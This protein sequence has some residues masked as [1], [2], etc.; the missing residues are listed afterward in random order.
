[1]LLP[2]PL[3]Y[4]LRVSLAQKM[5]LAL[6]F[7]LGAIVILF[8]F[9]RLASVTKSIAE[10]SHTSAIDLAMW[11][12]IEC[13]VA[14]VVISLPSLRGLLSGKLITKTHGTPKGS[15]A[16]GTGMSNLKSGRSTNNT[17]LGTQVNAKGG[18]GVH[19][20]LHDVDPKRVRDDDVG[21]SSSQ[22]ELRKGQRE[23][24]HGG[25]NMTREVFVS[26]HHDEEN[27]T[28]PARGPQGVNTR[29]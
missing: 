15:S 3:L 2:L 1:M 14:V 21:S 6:I 16:Y 7:C 4:G 29:Y 23:S 8:C 27:Q 13:V 18:T 22:E 19:I 17:G 9:I 12:A 20:R 25:I 11:S 24:E 28:G 10:I 26:S 5:G